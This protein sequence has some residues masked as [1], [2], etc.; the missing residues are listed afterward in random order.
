MPETRGK[1]ARALEARCKP[2][3]CRAAR[4]RG[5]RRKLSAVREVFEDSRF[6][7]GVCVFRTK[8]QTP[9][10]LNVARHAHGLHRASNARAS[11]GFAAGAKLRLRKADLTGP[12]DASPL[13][14]NHP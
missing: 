11:L 3:A 10:F 2:C 1:L 12:S 13:C 8:T 4:F 9:S 7:N 5:A 14:H 6:T